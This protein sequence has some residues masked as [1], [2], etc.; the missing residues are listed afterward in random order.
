MPEKNL[1]ASSLVINTDARENNINAT[2]LMASIMVLAGHMAVLTAAP[3]P[4]LL[5]VPVHILGIKIFF[6]LGGY[7][8]TKSWLNDPHPIR[9]A[10]KRI[11]RLLPALI[12][13][14]LL[15]IFVVGPIFTTLSVKEYF[16][17]PITWKYL[18]NIL[19][20]ISF[21]LPGVFAENTVSSAV[22][23]SLWSL[24]IEALMYI[25]VP[26]MLV[27]CQMKNKTKK[28]QQN[29]IVFVVAVC[30]LRLAQLTFFSS[31]SF[32]VYETDLGLALVNA[33]FYFIGC[34]FTQQWVRKYLNTQVAMLLLLLCSCLQMDI[35]KSEILMFFILPY[36]VFSFV[37]APQPIFKNTFKNFEV[38]YGV[39]LYGFTVQQ[40]V[41]VLFLR[42]GMQLSYSMLLLISFVI[43]VTV[44]WISNRLVEIPAQK[45]CKR[46]LEKRLSM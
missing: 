37:L 16:S 31:W 21:S 15:A 11:F 24:P 2:R 12:L 5:G 10:V 25:L 46:I 7:L 26:V 3:I 32:I 36:F 1:T 20:K 30:L 9:Y 42:I 40:C 6:L 13:F 35:L 44:A 4:T 28:S 27:I 41:I 17:N 33:P 18:K 22:N 45:L 29:V 23:G 8:I 39:F 34:I 38:A 43:T 19:L 14:T